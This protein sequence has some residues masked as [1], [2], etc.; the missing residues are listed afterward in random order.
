MRHHE[1]SFC[2][3]PLRS[4]DAVPL[5]RQVWGAGHW[6]PILEQFGEFVVQ[7]NRSKVPTATSGNT[8]Q[9]TVSKVFASACRTLL[10]DGGFGG[11]AGVPAA[12]AL[13]DC[14]PI[15]PGHHAQV[16][17][18]AHRVHGTGAAL[19]RSSP[20][21][22]NIPNRSAP[23]SHTT[24]LCLVLIAGLLPKAKKF[25]NKPDP[26]PFDVLA[27]DMADNC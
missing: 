24:V 8:P 20:R 22:K 10:V 12:W 26:Q 9:A 21:R 3:A 15:L 11:G 2:V 1:Q 13:K 23:T 5:A 18:Q 6:P 14:V 27:T 16:E 7:T 19:A 25:L 4:T 17:I